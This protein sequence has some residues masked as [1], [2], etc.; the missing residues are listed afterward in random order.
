M[1]RRFVRA[2]AQDVPAVA[3]LPGAGPVDVVLIGHSGQ[4]GRAVLDRLALL[5]DAEGRPRL[6]V[7]ELINRSEHA[8]AGETGWAHR[9]R[10]PGA[11]AE[12]GLRIARRKRPAVVIDCTADPDLP[13]LYPDW[14]R[15]GIGVVTPNKHGFAGERE[16]YD[17]IHAAARSAEA[18]LG[19]A[20]TVGAGLPVLSTL[21]RL[22]DS[23]RRP[24]RITAVVSGTLVQV[25]GRMQDGATLSR[26]VADARAAGCTEPDPLDDLSG[27]DVARKLRIL[28]REAGLGQAMDATEAGIDREPVVEDHWA[29]RVRGRIDVIEALE[30]QDARWAARLNAAQRQGRRWIYRAA[31][32]AGAAQV[33]PTTV[34]EDDP[35]ARLGGSDNRLVLSAIGDHSGDH[36]GDQR[37]D[38]NS[39]QNGDREAQV[40]IEGPGAGIDVT[41]TSVLADLVEAA[42]RL[43]G[44]ARALRA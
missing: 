25:F 29:D 2:A 17:R 22:R 35:F 16:R 5:L 28:L 37:G 27:R 31:F 8:I 23:G 32:E 26:A 40:V 4:V 24:G 11:L 36:S 6:R 20:A 13:G 10:M 15:A 9:R 14:L 34:A 7:G 1:T 12:L 38:R 21:R 39:D 19:Y 18:P 3:Q 42:D 30:A 41:A 43:A 44:R 33:G